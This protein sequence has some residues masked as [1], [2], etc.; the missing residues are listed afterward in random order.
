MGA[1][2]KLA[3]KDS[4]MVFMNNTLRPLSHILFVIATILVVENTQA[5]NNPPHFVY[6]TR[7]PQDKWALLAATGYMLES[8]ITPA[9]QTTIATAFVITDQFL[10]STAQNSTLDS[11]TIA[12]N[13]AGYFVV[14]GALRYSIQK[15]VENGYDSN[16]FKNKC[17]LLEKGPVRD[18]CYP[19]VSKSA[20]VL[21][22]FF[23]EAGYDI[24]TILLINGIKTAATKIGG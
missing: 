7:N 17:D 23:Q 9:A 11:S 4:S 10:R 13:A 6:V 18:V 3:Q 24:A 21:V 2:F 15:S 16:Y 8:P 12:K 5:I 22:P 1:F 19:I 20:D 14:N